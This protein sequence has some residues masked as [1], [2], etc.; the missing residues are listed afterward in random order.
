MTKIK[1]KKATI[2][3]EL[4]IYN[5]FN[6]KE[7]ISYKIK[8]KKKISLREHTIW[9]KNF[10]KKELGS[11]YYNFQNKAIGNIRLSYVKTKIMK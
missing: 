2:K 4:L 8:T 5:W 3:D 6:N 11:I 10:F 1:L 9:I 7:N